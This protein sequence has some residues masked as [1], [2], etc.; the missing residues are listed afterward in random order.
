M[1]KAD[2]KEFYLPN[3]VDELKKD[4]RSVRVIMFVITVSDTVVEFVAVA[5]PLLL[6]ED[7]EPLQGSVVGVKEEHRERTQLG[8][9]VPS[10]ATVDDNTGL[11]VFYLNR[12]NIIS[13]IY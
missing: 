6:Y 8:R 12:Q 13:I 7:L 2:N 10:I 1:Y 4:R 3:T 11:V 9:P 5:Q